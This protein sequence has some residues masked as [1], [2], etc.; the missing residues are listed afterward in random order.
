[1]LEACQDINTYGKNF[2]VIQKQ[3]TYQ[4]ARSWYRKE[5]YKKIVMHLMY[6][7][8]WGGGELTDKRQ[9]VLLA[10]VYINE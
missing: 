7:R 10:T 1:M 4:T 2:P 9:R 6:V 8:G 3:Q 5:I